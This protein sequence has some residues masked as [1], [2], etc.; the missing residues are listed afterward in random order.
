[1]VS[2]LY[3]Q[4]FDGSICFV[5]QMQ[6]IDCMPLN[7]VENMPDA[8]RRQNVCASKFGE[9][10]FSVR[11]NDWRAGALS[12]V[13]S[14]QNSDVLGG[15]SHTA[16]SHPMST[17][18]KQAKVA[19]CFHHIYYMFNYILVFQQPERIIILTSNLGATC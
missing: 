8:L 18:L 5:H 10:K 1:M 6:D 9:T 12:R 15:P 11:A 16:T 4:Y 17:L 3:H 19:C 13:S 2:A 7:P 14:S